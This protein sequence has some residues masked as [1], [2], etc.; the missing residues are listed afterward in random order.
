MRENCINLHYPA[1]VKMREHIELH[2]WFYM[3]L[4]SKYN[5]FGFWSCSLSTHISKDIFKNLFRFPELS[6]PAKNIF[7]LNLVFPGYLPCAKDGFV[8]P[9]DFMQCSVAQ[10]Q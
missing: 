5:F 9:A 7:H 6:D 2:F 3:R 4:L 10:D 1:G 8:L